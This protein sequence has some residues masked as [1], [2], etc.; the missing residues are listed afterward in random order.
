MT[1]NYFFYLRGNSLNW[2]RFKTKFTTEYTD[3]VRLKE[4]VRAIRHW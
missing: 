2:E 4:E 1:A 3:L